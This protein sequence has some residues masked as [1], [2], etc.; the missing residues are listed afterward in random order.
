[1]FSVSPAT[2][3]CRPFARHPPS[4]LFLRQARNPAGAIMSAA[5][6]PA[7]ARLPLG[8]WLYPSGYSFPGDARGERYTQYRFADGGE[9][10]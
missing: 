1:M 10:Q 6:R 4:P 2:A 5:L 9:R 7:P 3:V 8:A